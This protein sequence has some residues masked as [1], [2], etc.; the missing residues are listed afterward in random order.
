M[1]SITCLPRNT[2]QINILRF[3]VACMLLAVIASA[4]EANS[5]IHSSFVA[6]FVAPETEL[7]EGAFLNA[8]DSISDEAKSTVAQLLQSG[9]SPSACKDLAEATIKDVEDSVKTAQ[10][11]LETTDD[12]SKC[13][14]E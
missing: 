13:K 4:S 2:M 12:G 9:K 5:E 10:K 3:T 6:D 11:I 14:D 1:G 7:V 8:Q